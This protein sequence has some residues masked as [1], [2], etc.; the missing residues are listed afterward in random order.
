VQGFGHRPVWR[1]TRDYMNNTAEVFLKREGFARVNDRLSFTSSAEATT[2]VA[3]KDPAHATIRGVSRVTLH[4]P[5]RT[6]DTCARGQ[7]QCDEQ[8]FHVTIQLEITMDGV[9]FH[10]RRWMK[11]MPRQL[12]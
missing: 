6:I 9:L 4:W 8:N 12:L 1:V 10:Q 11:S 5:E 2:L 7:S 3:E